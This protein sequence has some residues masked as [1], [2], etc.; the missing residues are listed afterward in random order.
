M[1]TSFTGVVEVVAELTPARSCG[2]LE[3]RER[4]VKGPGGRWI[5]GLRSGGIKLPKGGLCWSVHSCEGGCLVLVLCMGSLGSGADGNG[6]RGELWAWQAVAGAS[7]CEEGT[8]DG[9]GVAMVCQT[10]GEVAAVV[11]KGR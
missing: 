11:D 10:A 8:R 1:S 5:L 3:A 7:E 6:F 2:L 9:R 4:S